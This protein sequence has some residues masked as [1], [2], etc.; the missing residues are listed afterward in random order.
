MYL[1]LQTFPAVASPR[2]SLYYV[3]RIYRR[4]LRRLYI[5]CY[6]LVAFY[7]IRM[8]YTYYI[9]ADRR[10]YATGL[11]MSSVCRLSVRNVLWLNGAKSIGAK[12]NN[13]DLCLEVVS[14]SR[15]PLRY[16]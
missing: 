6:V 12:I 13:L 15:Q 16:I 5:L 11:R 3:Q 1:F 14:R 7:M 4:R 8:M 9:L 10:A 2:Y